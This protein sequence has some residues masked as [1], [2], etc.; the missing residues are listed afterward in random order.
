MPT[1]VSSDSLFAK[2]QESDKQTVETFLKEWLVSRRAKSAMRFFHSKAFTNKFILSDSC[3]VKLGDADRSN[4]RKVRSAVEDFL[5]EI[6]KWSRGK[7][8]QDILKAL[9]PHD[10]DL[11]SG[12]FFASPNQDGYLLVR[13]DSLDVELGENWQYLK[14]S[15]P[16]EQ[17]LYL[18]SM[19]RIRDRKYKDKKEDA[20]APIYSIWALEDR[21][22]R[23][24]HFG[25]G[26][27]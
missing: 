10:L 14:S 3:I 26:C 21:N 5:R 19:V 17:Y 16:S 24:I 1:M 11:T 12:K 8:L 18:L 15:F 13:S 2:T 27:I 7:S 20:A 4:P 6:L 9:K 23:I 25:M 22:W